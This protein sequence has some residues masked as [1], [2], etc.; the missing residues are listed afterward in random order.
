MSNA[1]E[2]EAK[3][4]VKEGDYKK[5]VARFKGNRSYTQTNYY[6]DNDEGLLRKEGVALRIREKEGLYEMTLK[7]PLSEGL[8]EKN[9]SWTKER[10]DAFMKKGV[11]PE[12]DIKRFLTMLDID[13]TTLKVLATLT[14]KRIDIDYE[15][16]KLS[17]DEN[18]YS[19]QVDYE[20]ELEHNS[21]VDAT[22]YL[23]GLFEE[24]KIPFELNAKTKVS[25]ALRAA[26]H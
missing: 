22:K 3:A 17:L 19:G 10:F 21:M 16:G 13:V 8:L 23:K 12:G 11:F 18:H 24:E 1:I 14:T 6:I 5:L 26:G 15:G 7:T 25:R 4:L 9:C 20:I 2:I